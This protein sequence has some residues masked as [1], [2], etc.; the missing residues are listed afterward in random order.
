MAGKT[1]DRRVSRTRTTLQQALITLIMKKRYETITVEDICDVANVGRSTF[2]AHY[3]S[4][5]DLKRR[6]LEEALHGLLEEHGRTRL[7]SP[8]KTMFSFSLP[9]F[10]HAKDHLALYR[11]LAGGR[12]GAFSL[13]HI[14]ELLTSVV[15][16]ELVSWRRG[17]PSGPM[18]LEA[19]V[20][21]VVGGYMALLTWW[22]DKG[23][24]ISPQEFD[25]LFQQF[26]TKGV[27]EIA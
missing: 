11:A 1:I 25:A 20:Q 9:M 5:D 6:G 14:E 2:Y 15:R 4:K 23:A 10:Q 21:F 18:P 17:K 3:T 22:L 27:L 8:G 16:D 19:A 7:A 26:A 12:G 13:Q 24:K